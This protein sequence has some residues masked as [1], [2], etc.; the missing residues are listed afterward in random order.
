MK[1]KFWQNLN[2]ENQII[3]FQKD[4]D[5]KELSMQ[6]FSQQKL[7]F[8]KGENVKAD[9]F[10]EIKNNKVVYTLLIKIKN[11]KKLDDELESNIVP[12]IANTIKKIKWNWLLDLKKDNL[13]NENQKKLL[14]ELLIQAFYKF[15]KYLS[16]KEKQ[17]SLGVNINKDLENH[18]ITLQNS[19]YFTKDLVNEPPTA[20]NPES[21]EEVIKKRFKTK[22]KIKTIKWEQLQKLWLN[23]IFYVWKG[24]KYPPRLIILEYRPNKKDSRNVALIWKGVT[25]D[26]W[27]YNLKPTGYIEDM[28][29]D[30]AGAA[31][32]LW[33]LDY[34]IKTNLNKNIVVAVPLVENLVSDRSFKPW[35]IIK[36]YNWKT[37]EV[38]NTDA[39]WRLILADSL[40]YIEKNYKPEYVFDFA[41]LTGAQLIALGN[42]IAAILGKNENLIKKI[43]KLSWQIKERVWELPLFGKYFEWM[44]SEIAD[45]NNIFWW[46][47]GPWTITAALFLSQFVKNKNWCH[48]DIAGPAGIFSG[49]DP[50]YWHWATGFWVRLGIEILKNIL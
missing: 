2:A 30:M 25:F 16:K 35:D 39:E 38:W 9:I 48:F 24:S 49:K 43:Q 23:G 3:I 45:M 26:A 15:D 44:K 33:I 13:L 10:P 21:M 41:T 5:L 7:Q 12:Q 32:V 36:M 17:Y 14:T 42:K 31:T 1:I 4:E 37:V 50:L 6:K 47:W 20:I 34:A 27:G 11:L 46:K 40:A 18:L 19:L 28:K 8:K 22:V 29:S